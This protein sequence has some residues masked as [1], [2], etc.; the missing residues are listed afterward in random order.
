MLEVI[1]L[2]RPWLLGWSSCGL[3][4]FWLQAVGTPNTRESL[5]GHPEGV[6]GLFQL[7][8]Q[9]LP[10]QSVVIWREHLGRLSNHNQRI[11]PRKVFFSLAVINATSVSIHLLIKITWK[12]SRRHPVNDTSDKSTQDSNHNQKCQLRKVVLLAATNATSVSFHPKMN[13]N[14][15]SQ[16]TPKHNKNVILH[17][18]NKQL[19]NSN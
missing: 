19:A 12:C 2:S 13:I 4:D 18:T 3:L 10:F 9:F 5:G 16:N 14:A 1:G 8:F 17:D 15:S 7:S 11:Q 6:L